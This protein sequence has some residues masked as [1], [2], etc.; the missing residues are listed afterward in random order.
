MAARGR[1]LARPVRRVAQ[2]RGKDAARVSW[3]DLVRP[4]TTLILSPPQVVDGRDKPGH[5]TNVT[6][7]EGYLELAPMI[8]SGPGAS[9]REIAGAAHCLVNHRN[10]SRF[11]L[12]AASRSLRSPGLLLPACLHA[13]LSL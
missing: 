2:E 3:P 6:A 5:D 12:V 4:S 10:A 9:R 1:P 11:W 8:Q 13:S 7:R